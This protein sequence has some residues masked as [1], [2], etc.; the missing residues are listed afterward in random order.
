MATLGDNY[1]QDYIARRSR[2]LGLDP[3]AVLAVASTEGG[4]GGP[5]STPGDF[6]T[7]FGP[8]QLHRGGALPSYVQDP[9]GW[10][11]STAG[12]DYALSRIASVARGL[13]GQDAISNI[14]YRFERPADPAAETAKAAGRYGN[15]LGFGS[16]TGPILSSPGGTDAITGSAFT[17][18]ADSGGGGD[19]GGPSVGYCIAHGCYLPGAGLFN[20]KCNACPGRGNADVGKAAKDI[21]GSTLGLA[22]SIWQ[23][24]LAWLP[25]V[26]LIVGGGVLIILGIVLVGREAATA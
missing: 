24:L 10:S 21:Y 1:Y 26:G 17:G 7:S 20:S 12:I 11:W 23:Q 8:F 15:Y 19:S 2:L 14:V 6:G 16:N 22:S 5:S 9:Q 25:R 4:F 18:G 3:A 13:V